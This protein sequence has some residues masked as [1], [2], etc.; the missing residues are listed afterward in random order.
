M[1]I[2]RYAITVSVAATFMLASLTVMTQGDVGVGGFSFGTEGV[3]VLQIRGAIVCTECSPAKVRHLRPHAYGF[4]QLS[5]RQGWLV[6]QVNWVS[7]PARWTHV[8]WPPRLW[9][10]GDESLLQRLGVEENLF[11]EIEIKGTLGNSR[12]LDISDVT[13]RGS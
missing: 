1:K 4:Y 2:L 5:Y 12:I 10:R 13:V 8:V 7:N 3:G 11:K 6:M 9:L